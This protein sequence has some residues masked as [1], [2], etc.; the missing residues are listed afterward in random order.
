MDSDEVKKQNEEKEMVKKLLAEYKRKVNKEI[1]KNF[2]E[3][4]K[5]EK[6]KEGDI[7]LNVEQAQ[8]LLDTVTKTKNRAFV[9]AKRGAAKNAREF[10]NH[11]W[12]ILVPFSFDST[13]S[14]EMK[15]HIY[16][17][18]KLWND[19]TCLNIVEDDEVSPR[20][21][22]TNI[23][24][25]G[26][27]ANVGMQS[28]EAYQEVDLEY[29]DCYCLGTMAHEIGHALGFF[30]EHERYDRDSFVWFYPDNVDPENHHAFQKGTTESSD[31]YKV[32]YDLGSV[33]HYGAKAF[34][35]NGQHTL[36]PRAEACRVTMNCDNDGFQNPDTCSTCICPQG[37]IGAKCQYVDTVGYAPVGIDNTCEGNILFATPN[38]QYINGQIGSKNLDSKTDYSYCHWQ[39]FPDI[40]QIILI[41]V[42]DVGQVCGDGCTWGNTEIR[43]AENRGNTGIRLCCRSDLGS[44][45]KLTITATNGY[46]LISLYSFNNIQRFSINFRQY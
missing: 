28:S 16:K 6:L 13:I 29:P 5:D 2:K 44:S 19:N 24:G 43:T 4:E 15:A 11:K 32:P 31:N 30:H 39:I 3:M 10:P 12:P 14:S 21:Q 33:M 34:S 37:Y 18:V 40:G 35:I 1:E 26:C 36:V 22:F 45:G 9:R 42:L 25:R 46:A 17:A 8:Y 23:V 27:S 7:V 41:E 38:W 20:I